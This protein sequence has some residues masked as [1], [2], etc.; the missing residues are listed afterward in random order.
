[1]EDLQA[2]RGDV[3][4]MEEAP[5]LPILVDEPRFHGNLGPFLWMAEWVS[6]LSSR[7][8]SNHEPYSAP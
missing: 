5:L 6:A 1:M 2:T 8:G 3:T 7:I 4:G